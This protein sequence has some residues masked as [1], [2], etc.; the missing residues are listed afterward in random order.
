M[1]STR[2]WPTRRQ[3]L[4]GVGGVATLALAPG[5]VRAQVDFR[6]D[7]FGLGVASGDP[8]PDGFVLWTRLAPYPLEPERLGPTTYLVDWDVARDEAFTNIAATG[9]ARAVPALAHAVHVE[10]AGLEAN[11]WYF[12]RFRLGKSVSRTGRARTLPAPDTALDKLRLSYASCA[13]FEHGFFTAYKFMAEDQPD[14]ILHLGDYIYEGSWGTRRVRLFEPEETVTLAQYRRR[15]A[16]Y[17][18]DP[19]LQRAHAAAPWVVVFD[20]HEVQN[21]FAGDISQ[22]AVCAGAAYNQAAFHARRMAAYQAYYEHMPLRKSTLL[23]GGNVR[24]NRGFAYGDL[25]NLVMLDERSFRSP[26]ACAAP[27]TPERCDGPK[28]LTPGGAGGGQVA[29]VDASCKAELD[30]PKR[31]ILGADQESWAAGQLKSKA[32]WTA[33]GQGVPFAHLNQGTKDAPRIWTDG[34]SGYP[35]ARQRLVNAV[36]KSGARNPVFLTGDVHAY[37]VIDVTADA[38]NANSPVIGTEFVG[39]SISAENSPDRSHLMGDLNPRAL[40]HNAKTH[41]Y[42][43]M[44]FARDKLE[45]RLVVVNDVTDPRTTRADLARFAIEA[46]RPGAKPVV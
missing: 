1:T 38:Q 24:L 6:A 3:L 19:D 44:D 9:T 46:G 22:D 12:Y 32:I 18:T 21:D 25:V 8:A 30:D 36:R 37:W 34:W 14:L 28:R 31:T 33:I 2:P 27:A 4:A 45:T 15:Y 17:R 13:H 7:P 23:A 43:L 29:D 41:G 35:P 11:R 5:P 26:Q 16:T 39:T 40:F 42:V 20:D 10:V